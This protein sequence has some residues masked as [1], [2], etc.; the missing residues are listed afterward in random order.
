MEANLVRLNEHFRLPFLPELIA[1]KVEGEEGGELSD[2]DIGLIEREHLRL[3]AE[4]ERQHAASSLPE[5]SDA[6]A[7][8]HDLLVR[9]RLGAR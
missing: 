7:D 6:R 1:Q 5:H 3:R 2:G 9:L 8:L 4:L